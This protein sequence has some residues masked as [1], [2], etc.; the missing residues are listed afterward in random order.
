MSAGDSTDSAAAV[1]ALA[2]AL[3]QIGCAPPDR[4][5]G[6]VT[7]WTEVLSAGFGK[8]RPTPEIDTVDETPRTK[9]SRKKREKRA[10][11]K[12]KRKGPL[13][14]SFAPSRSKKASP[15]TTTKGDDAVVPEPDSNSD[16]TS[17]KLDSELE[18]AKTL[19]ETPK[20]D[21]TDI[22][23]RDAR[24]K[25]KSTFDILLKSMRNDEFWEE[26]GP[27]GFTSTVDSLCE[28]FE[29]TETE[30]ANCCKN[31]KRY[32]KQLESANQ[33]LIN[34]TEV[35]RDAHKALE[36]TV[37]ELKEEIESLKTDS[38]DEIEE[39]DRSDLSPRP[40]KAKEKSPYVL[41]QMLN[42]SFD[43]LNVYS[44]DDSTPIGEWIERFKSIV[45]CIPEEHDHLILYHLENRLDYESIRLPFQ[46]AVND[47]TI[48]SSTTAYKYLIDT[49]STDD[50]IE[51]LYKDFVSISQ[52][53][54][55]SIESYCNK[56]ETLIQRMEA[57]DNPIGPFERRFH[58]I[59]GMLPFYREK[60]EEM[61]EYSKMSLDDVITKAKAFEKSRRT[62]NL[63][64]LRVS[65][66]KRGYKSDSDSDEVPGDTAIQ[67]YLERNPQWSKKG[68]PS[69]SKKKK[70][71]FKQR[72]LFS[73]INM[74]SLY[75]K[76]SKGNFDSKGSDDSLWKERIKKRAE[77]CSPA[78]T[79]HLYNRDKY[80]GKSACIIC[81]NIGHSANTCF[82]LK[83]LKR[84]GKIK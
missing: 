12:A 55:E 52:S 20:T 10:R 63:S 42:P 68:K 57:M 19:F 84:D 44:A 61:P 3:K 32:L 77:K 65:P 26:D 74:K 51:N 22:Q 76:D 29:E 15:K 37:S 39:I 25:R 66:S 11:Q 72:G 70:G 9:K 28:C 18:K 81:K 23:M 78:D 31:H 6:T 60:L 33:D 43:T 24:I 69:F 14:P 50:V 16:E 5:D 34:E 13:A 48:S 47:N 46:R 45:K 21:K 4:G 17:K 2:N 41:R 27:N 82:R 64:A 7:D 79:P 62:A 59:S 1:S 56:R 35:V 38:S 71:T 54:S 80:E 30:L 75:L 73:S 58:F 53:K 40:S 36:L 67:A 83:D 8:K 49:Y